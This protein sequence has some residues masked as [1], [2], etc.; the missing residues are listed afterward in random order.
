MALSLQNYFFIFKV[1]PDY[2]RTA[3]LFLLQ[4]DILSVPAVHLTR[5][6]GIKR[7][8]AHLTDG[9]VGG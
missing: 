3:A 5:K 8:F 2:F 4:L 9:G 6:R 1:L 7:R